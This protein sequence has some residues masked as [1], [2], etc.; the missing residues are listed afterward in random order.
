MNI[1]QKERIFFFFTHAIIIFSLFTYSVCD[2][3]LKKAGLGLNGS[4]ML[5]NKS[6]KKKKKKNVSRIFSSMRNTSE[7]LI[8]FINC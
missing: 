5:K 8:I 4:S 2:E 6:L 1:C 3:K 7:A